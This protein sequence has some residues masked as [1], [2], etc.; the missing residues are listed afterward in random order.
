MKSHHFGKWSHL[1]FLYI[2]GCIRD[3]QC[4]G[5]PEGENIDL[6]R[7]GEATRNREAWRSLVRASSSARWWR[8]GLISC[9]CTLEGVSLMKRK[10]IRC[11]IFSWRPHDSHDPI[12]KSWRR[13][14]P[15]QDWR[16]CW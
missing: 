15:P 6:T 9:F 2:R 16:L 13:N 12:P 8:S 14:P 11:I 7:I 3:G 5:I 4:Q 1:M 10:N